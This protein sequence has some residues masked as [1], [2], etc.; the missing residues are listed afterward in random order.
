MKLKQVLSSYRLL[1]YFVEIY[2]SFVDTSNTQI[3]F[4]KWL[5]QGSVVM[6]FSGKHRK[7]NL[8]KM[9]FAK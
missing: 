1:L 3:H 4:L 9:L 8:G 2:T 5:F 7:E 6:I